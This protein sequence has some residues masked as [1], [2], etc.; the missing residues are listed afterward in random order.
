[1]LR[2]PRFWL[3]IAGGWLVFAAL[4]HT[5]AHVW[6]L[7]LENGMLGLREFTMNAMKQARSPDPLTPSMWREFRNYS[8]AF[9]LLLFFAGCADLLV[10]RMDAPSR[11][12]ADFALYGTVFWTIAFIPWA[13]V[14]PVIQPLTVAIVAVPLHAI[15]YLVSMIEA[16]E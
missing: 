4:A 5:A 10:A 11:V 6:F 1:M 16:E 8:S 7:V 15:A 14:D 12:R 9:G 3:S 2:S 13:F